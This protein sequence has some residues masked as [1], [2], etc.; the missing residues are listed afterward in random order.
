LIKSS[1]LL[2]SHHLSVTTLALGVLIAGSAAV[3]ALADNGASSHNMT[4]V[5]TNDLQARSTYQPTVHKYPNNRYI[6]FAGH[7]ALA[8]Q[9]EGL[10]PNGLRLPSFNPLTGMNELNG[11][12]I[13]ND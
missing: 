9:G 5:G 3:E 1:R 6:L 13:V 12:S 4:L 8:S 10:F 2:L 7:H 11:T